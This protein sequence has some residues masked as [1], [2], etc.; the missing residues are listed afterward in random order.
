[1]LTGVAHDLRNP[2]SAI[3][4]YAQ[5]MVVDEEEATRQHR[6]DRVLVQI[7]EMTAMVTDL[8][9]F[10][11]GDSS[12]HPT[13]TD[14]DKLAADIE[15]TLRL[16]TGPRKIELAV[17]ASG[18]Q[19][20]IDSSRAKRIVFN[21]AKNAVD[22]LSRGDHLSIDIGEQAGGLIVRVSDDGPGLPEEVRPRLFQ[23]FVTSGKRN[24][25]GLGLSIVKRF[26]DDHGGQVEV[27]SEL[28]RGTTFVV[29]L[30]KVS[31][32]AGEQ[33]AP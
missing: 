16:Y 6:C 5:L 33:E 10:A 11:R 13:H 9:A 29:R 21:L 2:M 20:F 32:A 4:G 31:R 14:I 25:V 24:G 15:E 12:L 28:E 30:P 8:L 19:A 23:P 26:V 27:S 22:V 3:S 18:G 7:D 1:M 17:A